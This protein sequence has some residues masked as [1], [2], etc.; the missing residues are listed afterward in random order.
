MAFMDEDRDVLLADFGVDVTVGA[1][2][3]QAIYDIDELIGEAPEGLQLA[4]TEELVV[5]V[6]P[7]PASFARDATIVIAGV[8]SRV[9]R[10]VAPWPPD[11]RFTAMVVA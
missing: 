8:G 7:L 10:K 1:D 9:I 4:G 5:A 2:T 3:V 6:A 11:G